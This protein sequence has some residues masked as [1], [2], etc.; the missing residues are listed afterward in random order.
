MEKLRNLVH[1]HLEEFQRDRVI[2]SYSIHYTKLYDR[3]VIRN[4]GIAAVIE[5]SA[6]ERNLLGQLEI[7]DARLVRLRNRIRWGEQLETD[8]FPGLVLPNGPL[9]S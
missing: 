6:E 8:L 3:L 2:T 9:L 7:M 5:T 1:R 4:G